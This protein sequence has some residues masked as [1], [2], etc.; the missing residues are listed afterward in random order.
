MNKE[1]WNLPEN[2]NYL[3]NFMKRFKD[4]YKKYS[5][6]A[7]LCDDNTKRSLLLKYR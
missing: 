1:E 5:K 3:T 2:A 7:E 6:V 4:F